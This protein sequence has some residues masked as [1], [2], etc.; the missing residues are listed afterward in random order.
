MLC[1]SRVA[2]SDFSV[3][4]FIDNS[5]SHRVAGVRPGS[6]SPVPRVPSAVPGRRRR[7]RGGRQN[8]KA[9]IGSKLSV[10]PVF[11]IFYTTRQAQQCPPRGPAR[12]CPRARTA[13]IPHSNNFSFWSFLFYFFRFYHKSPPYWHCEFWIWSLTIVSFSVLFTPSSQVVAPRRHLSL[14]RRLLG[15]FAA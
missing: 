3:T 2:V 11:A 7:A 10:S 9:S 13:V 8:S 12:P 1:A 4:N 14:R 6:G 15:H 5:T